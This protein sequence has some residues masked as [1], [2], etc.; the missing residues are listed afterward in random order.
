S[1][2]VYA[3]VGVPYT[4]IVLAL[5]LYHRAA[6]IVSSPAVRGA[7]SIALSYL[8][9]AVVLRIAHSVLITGTQLADYLPS[10]H[11]PLVSGTG[12]AALL[13]FA[14]VRSRL[15]RSHR[16]PALV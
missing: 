12:V 14:I 8:A 7:L 2:L 15:E 10:T 5:F 1:P 16:V 11:L 9:I 4:F 13:L 6:V 3:F